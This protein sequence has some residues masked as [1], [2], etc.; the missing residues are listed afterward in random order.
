[1]LNDYTDCPNPWHEYMQAE[2]LPAMLAKYPSMPVCPVCGELCKAD[3]CMVFYLGGDDESAC[4]YGLAYHCCT[5]RPVV[6]AVLPHVHP[7]GCQQHVV[8]TAF[9]VL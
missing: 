8:Y 4:D 3:N 6:L 5:N 7:N 9:D 1:M 2:V